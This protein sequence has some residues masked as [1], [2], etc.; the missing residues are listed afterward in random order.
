MPTP[1]V[2]RRSCRHAHPR[3]EALLAGLALLVQSGCATI[4]W[5]RPALPGGALRVAPDLLDLRGVVHVHT[6]A[7]HDSP[8]TVEEVA[9]GARHAGVA[10]VAFTVHA[11]P[12]VAPPRGRVDGVTFIPG[13]EIRAGGGSILALGITEVLP[14][15][16]RP[17]DVV[18]GIHEAGGLAFVAHVERSRLVD[19]DAYGEL[20]ADG[21]ELA[22]L[23]AVANQ[24]WA[25]LAFRSLLLPGSVALRSLVATPTANLALWDRLPARS[26]VGAVDAHAKYRLLGSLGG[27]VDRYRDVF[28]L[29]TTHV[30]T[31][32]A[33][34]SSILEAL[35]EG[36]S[37]V[38]FEALG[39][40]D[41]FRFEADEG[42]Y[43]VE[44]PR[45]ARL[46]LV[47]DGREVDTARAARALL[48][49]PAGAQRCRAEAWLGER[50]WVVTSYHARSGRP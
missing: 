16:A 45:D 38:A 18:R 11:R 14:R 7:S 28:R 48:R 47:C 26:I 13:F 29:L 6:R 35:R 49:P 37:Y 24:R 20:S 22:N 32:D 2:Q 19:P 15:S 42:R 43:R 10:W 23:H 39:N 41:G 1:R 8:G 44:T 46:A 36:R 27:N 12:G 25:R 40:V 21:I 30:L 34:V 3:A 17:A 4:P 9:R 31:P 33:Q 5:P 50:L